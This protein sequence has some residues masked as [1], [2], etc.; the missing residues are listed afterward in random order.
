MPGI[1]K[2]FLLLLLFGV[3]IPATKGQLLND[4]PTQNLISTGIN[5][6]YNNEFAAATAVSQQLQSRYPNHPVNY[7]VKAF[8]MYWQYLPI[9]DNKAKVG[10]YVRTLNQCLIA[11]E[12][13][14]GKNSKDPEAIFFT[15][16]ARG[17]L[18]LMYNY[19]NELMKAAGE[20]QKTYGT[21]TEGLKLTDKNSEFYFTTGMYNYYVEQYPED[22][23]IIKPIMFFFKNGNKPLGLR[24][25]DI[26][27]RMGSITKVEATFYL[28]HIYLEHEGRPDLAVKYT[29]Q[30]EDSFPRNTIF[31]MIHTE[32]LLLSGKYADA[33]KLIPE[34]RR[35]N[36]DFY[37]IAWHFFEGYLLEKKDRDYAKAQDEYLAALKIPHDEQYTREYHAMAYAGLARI[38]DRN[39]NQVSAKEY[40]RKCLAI[41]QYVNLEKE[42][43]AYMK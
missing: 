29:S 9:Q 23:P 38:A 16:A 34:L 36:D 22:H 2:L 10:E 8:A 14:Y 41:A 32:A 17:Y 3:F 11:V 6:I 42:A 39:N 30:L 15:L 37:P 27:T 4:K 26:A 1:F 19:Q 24:Q 33:E 20:A 5:H 31:K 12:K 18:A 43:T 40:Y 25:L 28:A 35:R 7:I 13:Q 21:L